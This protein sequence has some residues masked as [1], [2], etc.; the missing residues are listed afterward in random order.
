M[1]EMKADGVEKVEETV[2][3]GMTPDRYIK[4]L[5]EW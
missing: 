3:R 4:P 1:T 5:R 2:R